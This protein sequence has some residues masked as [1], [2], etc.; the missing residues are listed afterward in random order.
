MVN[1]C[2]TYTAHSQY[3]YYI[4]SNVG[5]NLQQIFTYTDNITILAPAHNTAYKIQ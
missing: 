4:F 5:Q 3:I 1:A 2:L